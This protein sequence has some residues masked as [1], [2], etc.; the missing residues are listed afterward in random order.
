MCACQELHI[1]VVVVNKDFDLVGALFQSL[2]SR[3][4]GLWSGSIKQMWQ[5][6]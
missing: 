2:G 3:L 1:F 5:I 4:E 6:L